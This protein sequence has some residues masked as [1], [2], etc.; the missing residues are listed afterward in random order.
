MIHKFMKNYR[1]FLETERNRTTELSVKV[2]IIRKRDNQGVGGGGDIGTANSIGVAVEGV[3]TLVV[4]VGSARGSTGASCPAA[5]AR[6]RL[7]VGSKNVEI[8]GSTGGAAN[9]G[10]AGAAVK[11]IRIGAGARNS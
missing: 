11:G 3:A 5:T 1:E 4:G 9:E 6:A 7:S 8:D 10:C 2:I